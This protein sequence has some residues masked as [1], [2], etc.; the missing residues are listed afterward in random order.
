MPGVLDSVRATASKMAGGSGAGD[1]PAAWLVGALATVALLLS[2]VGVGTGDVPR[3]LRNHPVLAGTMF[4]LVI[5]AS[6]V[7]AAGAWRA[8]TNADSETNGGGHIELI[9]STLL[10]ALAAIFALITGIASSTEQPEPGITT[11]IVVNHQGER[12]L[13]FGVKDSDVKSS[14]KLT[15]KVNAVTAVTSMG[16]GTTPLY[17]ESLGPTASGDIDQHGEVKGAASAGQ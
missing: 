13:R 9:L 17:I 11:A 15:I 4:G 2:A 8:K 3:I 6:V 10:L 1:K 7:G 5:A 14:Q 16:M 12:V